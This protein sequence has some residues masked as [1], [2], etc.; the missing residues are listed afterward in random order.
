MADC[1]LINKG[2]GVVCVRCGRLVPV[3]IEGL[4]AE[5]RRPGWGD[6]LAGLIT[7]SGVRPWAGCGCRQRQAAVNSFEGRVKKWFRQLFPTSI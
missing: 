5:C 2:N 7:W 3:Q 1:E 6:R 4:R